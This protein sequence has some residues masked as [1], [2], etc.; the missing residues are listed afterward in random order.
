M[1]SVY[2]RAVGFVNGRLARPVS[3]NRYEFIGLASSASPCNLSYQGI[4]QVGRNRA[5]S[6]AKWRNFGCNL[7][8]TNTWSDFLLSSFNSETTNKCKST[9][10]E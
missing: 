4:P 1:L 9:K 2:S 6:K 8:P 7:V 10:L 3:V 5:T